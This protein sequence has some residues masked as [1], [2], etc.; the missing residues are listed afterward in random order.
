MPGPTAVVGAPAPEA[1]A[2]PPER[3]PIQP[4]ADREAGT[5]DEQERTPKRQGAIGA[6]VASAA[7]HYLKHPTSGFRNDCSGF[8]M[9][10]TAR[11]GVPVSGSTKS[12]WEAFK[13]EGATHLRKEPRV[14]DLAFFDNTTDRNRNGRVD[15][16]LTHIAVVIDVESDGTILLAHDGTGAGRAELRMNLQHPDVH[17]NDRGKVLNNHLRGRRNSD[18]KAT[19]YLS[20]ELW[21]GFATIRPNTEV[22]DL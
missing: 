22:A 19:R 17:I 6:S 12:L 18:P 13:S 2:L 7:R 20:G 14:G 15:D 10:A 1:P 16:P 11:A 9:A 8:V 5:S 4:P 3:S 21:R